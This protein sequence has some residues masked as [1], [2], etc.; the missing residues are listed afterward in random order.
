[1]WDVDNMEVTVGFK[2]T[3]NIDWD[4]DLKLGFADLPTPIEDGL[5]PWVVER[6]LG[7][8]TPENPIYIPLKKKDGAKAAAP[9]PA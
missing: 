7:G 4:I 5:L 9:A 1:M 2:T 8:F 3:P 6:V